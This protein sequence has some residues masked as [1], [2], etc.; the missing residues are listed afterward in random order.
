[1]DNNNTFFPFNG[2]FPN[3]NMNE[4]NSLMKQFSQLMEGDFME[5]I[6]HL[7]QMQNMIPNVTGFPIMPMPPNRGEEGAQGS[8]QANTTSPPLTPNFNMGQLNA[9]MQRLSS[10]LNNDLMRNMYNLQANAPTFS[11]TRPPQTSNQM[12]QNHSIPIQLWENNQQIYVLASLSGLK[13]SE[14]VKVTFLDDNRI[15][16]RAKAP[17]YRPEKNSRVVK[18]EFPR[19]VI[20]REI[21][22]PHPVS[23]KSYSANFKD[24]LYTLTL[25]KLED[26][27]EISIFD[28]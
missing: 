10:F 11:N 1:M 23:P 3:L 21:E 2:Q 18:S 6:Q 5:S 19:N 24:G 15:R 25:H 17:I 9:M 4:I 16:I 20:E 12:K 22:L 26:D 27:Y 8:S 13:S 28:E 14:D 7:A